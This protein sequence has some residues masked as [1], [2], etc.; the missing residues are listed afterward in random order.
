MERKNF[1]CSRELGG[2]LLHQM[3]LPHLTFCFSAEFN[4]QL[5]GVNVVACGNFIQGF[6]VGETITGVR[7]PPMGAPLLKIKDGIEKRVVH[8]FED[9]KFGRQCGASTF[10]LV[11]EPRQKFSHVWRHFI[12]VAQ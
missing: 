8:L 5:I 4:A 2:Y 9:F 3:E 12:F 10:P 11:Q 7:M 1:V 6:L